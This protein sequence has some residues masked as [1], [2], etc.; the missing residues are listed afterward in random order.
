MEGAPDAGAEPAPAAAEGAAPGP[1]AGAPGELA[2]LLIRVHEDCWLMIRDAD[3]R[4]VYRDLASAGTVLELSI[5]PPVRVV[6]G[7]AE[8]IE[9]EFNGE[10]VDL[11]PWV[12]QDTGTARFRLGS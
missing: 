2:T 1:A 8:G 7:Y 4:L 5:A 10:P 9:L 12:E 3:Q 11:S 6:A